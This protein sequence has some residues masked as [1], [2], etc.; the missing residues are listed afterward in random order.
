MLQNIRSYSSFPA[1]GT[2]LSLSPP[3]LSPCPSLVTTV[4]F[5]SSLK[6]TFLASTA[7]KTLVFLSL[8]FL[9]PRQD[10]P[11]TE[12]VHILQ[13]R[14]SAKHHAWNTVMVLR[15]RLSLVFWR[16]AIQLCGS[17]PLWPGSLIWLLEEQFVVVAS[18]NEN[19]TRFLEKC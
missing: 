2:I 17:L 14:Y 9:L 12:L 6:S 16:E 15:P 10:L 18:T 19:S 11:P 3:P 8:Y 5:F 7:K 4:L 13:I 1:V